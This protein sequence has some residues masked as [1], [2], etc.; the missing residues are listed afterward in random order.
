MK[1]QTIFAE[2]L[3]RTRA[4]RNLKQCEL[5]E[6]ADLSMN[7]MS[8]L[9]TSKSKPSIATLI[10]LVEALRVSTDYLLGTDKPS[11]YKTGGAG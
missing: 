11:P 3:R 5:A 10:K 2:R 7:T 9:E 1:D 4:N 6:K 8:L